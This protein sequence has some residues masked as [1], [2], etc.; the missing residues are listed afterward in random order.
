M[1]LFP[2]LGR[3][4]QVDFCV[5]GQPGQQSEFQDSQDVQE[6]LYWKNQKKKILCTILLEGIV[7]LMWLLFSY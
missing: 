2:E 3:P 1:P 6:T 5:P 4:T 7:K